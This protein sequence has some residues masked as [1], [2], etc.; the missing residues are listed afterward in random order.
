MGS[1]VVDLG[2]RLAAVLVALLGFLGSAR[3]V[4]G[5]ADVFA[6]TAARSAA[7][8]A[9]SIMAVLTRGYLVMAIRSFRA[10]RANR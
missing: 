8:I 10:A 7:V 5:L 9:Q 4:M 2:P 1:S 6:G 3:G